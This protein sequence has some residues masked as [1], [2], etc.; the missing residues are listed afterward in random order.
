VAIKGKGRSKGRSVARAPKRAP[1]PVPVPF[2]QRRWVQVT[3]ALVVGFAAFWLITWIADGVEQNRLDDQR[4]TQRTILETWRGTVESEI[5]DVGQ[6]RD[7]ASPLI[8]DQVRR[9]AKD[10]TKGK[11][12]SVDAETLATYAD[13][14]DAAAT[15]LEDHDLAGAIRDQGFGKSAGE[16]LSARTEMV[17][18]LRTYR[19]AARLMALAVAS[20]SEDSVAI[21]ERVTELLDTADAL[22]TNAYNSYVI[23][24]T[25]VGIE[26]APDPTDLTGFGS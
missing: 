19:S 8:A 12:P 7:P 15:A 14:L 9:A 5:G 25:D 24:L 1:V 11:Q 21:A 4:A 3:V 23:A 10:V 13:D 20:G 6:L 2:Y 17:V 16:I 18:A 22:M 26:V